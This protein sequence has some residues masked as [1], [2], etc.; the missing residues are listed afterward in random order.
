MVYVPPI[1]HCSPPFGEMTVMEG[2]DGTEPTVTL[3]VAVIAAIIISLPSPYD[4][5]YAA[6]MS[7]TPFEIPLTPAMVRS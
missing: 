4:G 2:T 3:A 5:L 1:C 6:L 7:A